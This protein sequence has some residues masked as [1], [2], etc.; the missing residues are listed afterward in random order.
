MT[1]PVKLMTPQNQGHLPKT[2]TT[3]VMLDGLAGPFK[4]HDKN[5]FQCAKNSNT[6]VM[7]KLHMLTPR[8]LSN[9]KY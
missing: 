9:K 7:E 3:P 8:S 1:T 2:M 6:A 5:R 4:Y